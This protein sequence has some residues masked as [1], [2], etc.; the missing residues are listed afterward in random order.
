MNFINILK[1]VGMKKVFC[2][3]SVAVAMASCG[4]KTVKVPALAYSDMDTTVAP[5]EDFY[6]Y[7]NGTW[8][9]NNPLKPEYARYGKFDALRDSSEARLNRL[10]KD[11]A[12][13]KTVAGT[14]EQKIV[15]LYQQGL[16]SVKLNSE[17]A[18]PVQKYINEVYALKDKA[19]VVKYIATLHDRGLSVFFGTG[20]ESDFS[21]SN[22]Q[23]L[24][25]SQ[26]GMN[27]GDKDYYLNPQKAQIKEGYLAYLTKVIGLAG[28]AEPEKV[29]K[30]ALDVEVGIAE[31]SWS[32]VELRNI[33]AQNNPMSTKDFEA[34]Y[35]G[36]DFASYFAARNIPDQDKMIVTQLSYFEKFSKYFAKAD[37]A[38]LKDYLAANLIND[39]ANVLSD[40]FYSAY[41]DF[42]SKQMSGIQQ[43]KPRWKRA[44]QVPNSILGEAVGK[45]YV[46]KYFP[47]TSKQKM[48]QLVDNLKVSLS[49]HIANLDWMGDS[50]KT[51][52][53][54]KLNSFIVKIGYPDKWKD[55]S[56][57]TI[58][59]SKSYYDNLV[60][61]SEWYVKDNM[62]KLGKET[63]KSEWGMTPQTVNAYYN[64]TT[65][66]ICFPAAILQ[67]P[68]FNPDADDA[69]NFGAIG[70]VI[71]HEM[72]HGFDDQGSL[73]DK[74][75]NMVN[76]WTAEDRAKFEEKGKKLVAQFDA[77]EVVPGVHANGQLCLGE[78]I[79]DNGGLNVAYTA[80]MN[81]YKGKKMEP[82]D[83]FT[84]QQRFYMSYATIWAQNI[85][86]KE[87]ERL[88]NI[89]P[90]SL[91]EFRVNVALRN[92]GTFFE[93]FGIKEGDKMY[94]PESERVNIW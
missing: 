21:N 4:T 69:V 25:V 60:A 64:P 53:Q 6:R 10:F 28:V 31:N 90:H 72:C 67:P 49:E 50:T 65:N 63:D 89:D 14:S 38:V 44:M 29:A 47:E 41:F 62:S 5:G 45:M 15:D 33:P 61:A 73:F 85:T 86:D 20:V 80:M 59:K 56:G 18:A 94:L 34:K 36:F 27:L 75:G 68:F 81:S 16:D 76:W 42:Y 77:V 51:K 32:N 30:N 19:E 22:M 3:L 82:I 40:E 87:K 7:V 35:P 78:N 24:Y 11:M 8:L 83:G 93:A 17:G 13:M 37:L 12:T 88:T 26:S 23:V 58:D 1:I 43:Q 39:A 84:P 92:F 57:L 46:A 48:L 70:V 55:Y 74:D 66:E 79:G 71:G 52:A 91:A 9:K 2:I 54:E